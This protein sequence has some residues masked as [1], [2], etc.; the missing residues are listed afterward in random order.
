MIPKRTAAIV[1]RELNKA[2]LEKGIPDDPEDENDE[3]YDVSQD[4]SGEQLKNTRTN[5]KDGVLILSDQV[6]RKA[7]ETFNSLTGGNLEKANN[8]LKT[9]RREEYEEEPEN[10]KKRR[11]LKD[12]WLD[13]ML[14]YSISSSPKTTSEETLAIAK[15]VINTFG[16]VD[17][18]EDVKFAGEIIQVTKKKEKSDVIDLENQTKSGLSEMIDGISK[19]RGITTVEKSSYDWEKY[20]EE[21]K[22]QEELQDASKAG[23]VEKQAFL[24]RV[25]ERQFEIE[26]SIRERERVLREASAPRKDFL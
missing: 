8:I 2:E 14:A 18:S 4:D 26:R 13:P 17:I 3:D 5:K 16:L 22:L 21:N 10:S 15:T 19:K 23:F 7:Q 20:K 25:D 6:M 9:L 1:A 24:H 11:R 12:E